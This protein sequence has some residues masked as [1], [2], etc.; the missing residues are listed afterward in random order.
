MVQH[1]MIWCDVMWHQ[2]KHNLYTICIHVYVYVTC[3]YVMY[4]ELQV[5][6]TSQ[7]HHSAPSGW[8]AP[9]KHFQLKRLRRHKKIYKDYEHLWNMEKISPRATSSLLPACTCPSLPRQPPLPLAIF[10]AN[11]AGHLDLSLDTN[12]HNPSHACSFRSSSSSAWFALRMCA[13]HCISAYTFVA[14]GRVYENAAKYAT[15]SNQTHR[16][17]MSKTPILNA[18]KC[19]APSSFQSAAWKG[20]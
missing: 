11:C 12:W 16:Q 19:S 2:C 5:P 20:K 9:C 7:S 13:C 3:I 17:K 6:T 15:C 8:V 10:F 14:Q 4:G 18:V 1:D